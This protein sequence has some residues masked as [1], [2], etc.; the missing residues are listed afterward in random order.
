MTVRRVFGSPVIL[1]TLAG[2]LLGALTSLAQGWLPGAW[3]QIANSG[4]VWC[5][6][7]FVTGAL[8]SRRGRVGL[9]ISC[10][11][12]TEVGL[13]VGYYGYAELG[14]EGMGR[15]FFPLVWLFMA[16]IAGPF[17][18]AAGHWWLRGRT[19]RLRVVGLA[20]VAGVFGMEALLFGW[21]LHYTMQAWACLGISV[22][23]PLLSVFA[24]QAPST[25]RR[26]EPTTRPLDKPSRSRPDHST[27]CP[28]YRSTDT[29][30]QHRGAPRTA[31]PSQL[32]RRTSPD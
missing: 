21:D 13:V 14:R 3:N 7:A 9:A 2:L 24:R 12:A 27:G 15:L 30:A 11:V 8:V 31:P 10:G 18:G 5:V 20:S 23:V 17:F 25:N 6:A 26:S 19:T 16:C 28:A 1:P 32:R 22:L 29:T 4:A